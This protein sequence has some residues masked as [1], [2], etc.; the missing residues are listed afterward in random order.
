MDLQTITRRLPEQA[1]CIALL[2]QMRWPEKPVCPH[3]K[4]SRS[5]A[6]PKEL[7]HFCN[8]CGKNFSVTTNTIFHLRQVPL[9]KALLIASLVVGVSDAPTAADLAAAAN[10]TPE[11]TKQLLERIRVAMNDQVQRDFLMNL[12]VNLRT[13]PLRCEGE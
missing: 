1:D 3:C 4:R 12:A 8:A 5:S 13:P 2:E 6:R 11:A 7:R 10:L 9:Q